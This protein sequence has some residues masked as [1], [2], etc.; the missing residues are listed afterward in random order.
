MLDRHM[1]DSFHRQT[2]F[3]S[4]LSEL[5][6]GTIVM[7]GPL[8]LAL[9]EEN[10]GR[11]LNLAKKDEAGRSCGRNWRIRALMLRGSKRRDGVTRI[12]TDQQHKRF[13]P[14]SSPHQIPHLDSEM[15]QWLHR[16]DV[17]KQSCGSRGWRIDAD[18]VWERLQP[19]MCVVRLKK[20]KR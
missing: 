15:N 2:G 18:S 11:T 1:V 8:G 20:S 6:Q 14:L 17:V 16:N 4:D 3:T 13:A 12:L 9:R 7:R 19:R 5:W 10:F